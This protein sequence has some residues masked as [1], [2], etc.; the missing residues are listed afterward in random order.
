M[1]VI[2]SAQQHPLRNE[3]MVPPTEEEVIAALGRL[4]I[5]KAAGKNGILPE[6]VKGCGGEML[7]HFIDL[8]STVWKEERVPTEW[9]DAIIVPIL[10]KGDPSQCDNWRGISL[11]DTTGRLFAKVMHLMSHTTTYSTSQEVSILQGYFVI[12]GFTE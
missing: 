3:L 8:F 11:L 10:K 9:R 5:N 12:S 1:S 4:Q 6:M 7:E 2:R